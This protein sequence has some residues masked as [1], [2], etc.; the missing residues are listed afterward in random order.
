MDDFTWAP[1]KFE[2]DDVK[3]ADNIRDHG[4]SFPEATTVFA[5]PRI[6]GPV[7][8]EEHSAAKEDRWVVTGMSARARPLVVIYC[9]RGPKIRIISAWPLHGAGRRTYHESDE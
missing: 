1:D 6:R 4:V 8:D 3:A 5:D 2:W 7:F 9:E